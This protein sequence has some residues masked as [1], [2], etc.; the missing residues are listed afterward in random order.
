MKYIKLFTG[1]RRLDDDR[2]RVIL[3]PKDLFKTKQIC[4]FLKEANN[5]RNA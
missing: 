3:D 4:K 5:T 1:T 2:V